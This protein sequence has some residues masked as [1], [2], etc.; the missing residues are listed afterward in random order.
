LHKQFGAG[1]EILIFPSDEFGKQELPAEQ[2]C[3]FAES[4]GVPCNTSGFHISAKV[5]VNGPNANPIW[6]LAKSK[7]AGDVEW[8]FAGIVR[9]S[10]TRT[11]GATCVA[12]PAQHAHAQSRVC[13]RC[14]FCST[15]AATW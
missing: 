1:L 14:S 5:Q 9:P 7:F 15:R 8:N 2:V 13:V 4:K 12:H 3:G 6:Q 11:A 10:A